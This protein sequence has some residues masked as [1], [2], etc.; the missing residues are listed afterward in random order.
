MALVFGPGFEGVGEAD[1]EG[2]EGVGEPV[3]GGAGDVG[4]PVVGDVDGG[5]GNPLATAV[6]EAP[7][8]PNGTVNV[9]DSPG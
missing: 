9:R 6:A 4:E 2:P 8:T 7:A 1:A 5:S 3:V